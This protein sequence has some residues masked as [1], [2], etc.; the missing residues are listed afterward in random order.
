VTL[1]I[2]AYPAAGCRASSR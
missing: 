2:E 1:L